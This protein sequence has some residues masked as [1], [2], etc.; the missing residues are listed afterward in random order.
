[1]AHVHAR[2]RQPVAVPDSIQKENR[3]PPTGNAKRIVSISGIF[4]HAK[5][6]RKAPEV[7]NVLSPRPA[8]I[9]K[10]K[11]TPGYFTG[12]VKGGSAVKSK[13]AEPGFFAKFRADC[14]KKP[15]G[16][17]F[18]GERFLIRQSMI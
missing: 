6:H 18:S 5:K 15:L 8:G 1:M 13:V 2:R 10:V 3:P 12:L 11:A 7:R 4:D 9:S 14:E 16:L 17:D